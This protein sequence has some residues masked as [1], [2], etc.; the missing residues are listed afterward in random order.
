MNFSKKGH[1]R[2]IAAALLASIAIVGCG[3]DSSSN[4]TRVNY[5]ATVAHG[6]VVGAECRVLDKDGVQVLDET[7]TTDENGQVDITGSVPKNSFP[8]KVS[9]SGGTYYN[10]ATGQ[11]VALVGEL[12]SI[13]PDKDTLTQ[14]GQKVAVTPLTDLAVE[15][16]DKTPAANKDPVAAK[17]ALEEVRKVLAP[18]LGV[19]GTD[20]LQAPTPV[21]SQQDTVDGTLEGQYAAYLAGLAKTANEDGGKTPE[22]ILTDLKQQVQ[23]GQVDQQTANKVVEKTKEFATEQGDQ[24][25]QDEVADDEPSQDTTVDT[26][27]GTGT[28]GTASGS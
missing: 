15:L 11:P 23:Q 10:E 13:V 16:F 27:T 18:S 1:V 28:G 24:S 9:C 20:L 19:D 7:F 21:K 6:A 2:S 5:Q 26:P 3:G 14:V 8:I 25:L 22:D 4:K 12:R 17:Q